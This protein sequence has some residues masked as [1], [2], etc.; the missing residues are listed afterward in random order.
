MARAVL[1]GRVG[2]ADLGDGAPLVGDTVNTVLKW[3]LVGV[4]T[5]AIL[6]VGLLGALGVPKPPTITKE[7]LGRVGWSPVLNNLG[8]IRRMLGSRT[9]VTWLPGDRGMVANAPRRVVDRR[10]HTV[11]GP[12][13]KPQFLAQIP[14]SARGFYTDPDYDYVVFSSDTGGN[15][16]FELYR[17]DLGDAEPVLLTSGRE[18]ATFGAFEPDG[19]R[20]AYTSTRRNEV[21]YDLYI[22][23]PLQPDSDRL[24]LERAGTWYVAD[25]SP[26]SA[27]LLLVHAPS[28]L[29][30][31]VFRLDLATGEVVPVAGPDEAP[32][33][34]GSIQYSRDGA[35]VYYSSDRDTEFKR[36]RYRDLAS[37]DETVLTA[38]VEWDVSSIAQSGDG[39]TLVVGVNEDGRTRYYLH[40]VATR[41][42]GPLEIPLSGLYSVGLHPR[43]MVLMVNHTDPSGVSRGYLYD[44][45]SGELTLWIGSEAEESDTP[46]GRLVRYPTFDEVDG[47]PREISA[48]VYPGVGDGPRPVMIEIHGGPE[49]QSRLTTAFQLPQKEG[50]TVITPNVRGSTGY[51]KTFTS[52]DDQYLREDAVRD[53][54]ALLDWIE[55]QPAMDAE[56]VM[57]SGGSYGGY[58]VLASLVHFGERLQCGIDIV[59]ISHFVTFLE[60]TADYRKDLRR[61]EYGDERDPAMRAF[62]DSISPLNHADRIRSRIMIVQGANDPRVP[63]TESRQFVDRLQENGL[64]VTYIEGAN[65]GHGFANPWNSMYAGIAQ[66]EM[67]LACLRP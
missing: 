46:A 2:D 31:V 26:A 58:M 51:G 43:E 29:E 11:A 32:A 14:R 56:R 10:L 37:G 30:R 12:G 16:Q 40:D 38:E 3:G 6:G 25:W 21:D 33:G 47:R 18:R 41:S 49:S 7:G 23:D 65:E 50:V 8:E 57:V 19:S 27:E 60:N 4:L 42:N 39:G 52:L 28:N 54:G 17:W 5:L 61:P 45:N 55:Q 62:L 64:E 9:L 53:I 36:L 24:V 66:M 48:F 63:V 35:G 44:R 34:I 13:A 20:I 59:G 1:G 67:S 15:E 22:M